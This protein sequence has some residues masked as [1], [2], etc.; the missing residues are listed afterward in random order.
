VVHQRQQV[1]HSQIWKGGASMKRST[2]SV[3]AETVD[4]LR[5]LKAELKEK[6]GIDLSI[7]QVIEYLIKER[8]KGEQS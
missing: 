8:S 7:A 6:I 5:Q 3:N 2:V 1:V 4:K